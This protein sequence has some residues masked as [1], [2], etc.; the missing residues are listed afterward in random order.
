VRQAVR[1]M[2]VRLSPDCP[3]EAVLFDRRSRPVT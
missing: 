3:L 2:W 1:S